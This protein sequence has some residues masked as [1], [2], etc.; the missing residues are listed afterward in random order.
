VD[1]GFLSLVNEFLSLSNTY[2]TEAMRALQEKFEKYLKENK[3]TADKQIENTI[4]LLKGLINYEETNNIKSSYELILPML[5]NLE[6]G[7]NME[8]L[9]GN[10][11]RKL[12][13]MSIS[14]C[15]SHEQALQF[16]NA[17]ED[18]FVFYPK[19]KEVEEYYKRNMY[20]HITDRLLY[21]KGLEIL[22]E[23]EVAEVEELFEEYMEKA[24]ILCVNR[25]YVASLSI[26]FAREGLF[27]G[28]KDILDSGT[29]LARSRR[30]SKLLNYLDRSL[31]QYRALPTLIDDPLTE[32]EKFGILL[33]ELR[34]ARKT[35][36]EDFAKMAGLS[37]GTI[38]IL[39]HGDDKV[40][41]ETLKKICETLGITE[42]Y[43]KQDISIVYKKATE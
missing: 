12:L 7:T 27:H 4:N 39:E 26:L 29:H 22:S 36:L 11:N 34:L 6:F 41:P 32:K 38:R 35:N 8:L 21:A 15:K 18:G 43:F 9:R 19:G 33:R 5:T 2:D 14:I 13:I 40:R 37:P 25:K 23:E 3:D 20:I 1:S 30:E 24:K 31:N 10:Y 17:I 28:D 16:L 42:D